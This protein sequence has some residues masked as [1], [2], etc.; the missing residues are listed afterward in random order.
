MDKI[1]TLYA[2]YHGTDA[3]LVRMSKY[4]RTEMTI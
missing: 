3:R 4:E 2:L 1:P